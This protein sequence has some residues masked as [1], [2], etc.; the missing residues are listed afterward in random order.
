MW[1]HALAATAQ[2]VR[3]EDAIRYRK[4][5][6]VMIKWHYD[7]LSQAAKGSLPLARDEIERNAAWLDALSKNA[8]EGFGVGSLEGDTKALAAIWRDEAKFRGL[9]EKFQADA[10]RLR[11]FARGGEA[12]ALK[13]PLDAM[14]RTCKSCHDDFKKS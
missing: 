9:V 8:A 13:A 14:T 11:Q 1:C 12:A 10:A 2:T 5:V 6:M 7:R 4:A 3:A